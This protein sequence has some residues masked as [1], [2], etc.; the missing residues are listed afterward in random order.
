MTFGSPIE[1]H[2]I[3]WPELWEEFLREAGT[4]PEEKPLAADPMPPGARGADQV[5][6]LP[7]FRGDPIAYRLTMRRADWI[8]GITAGRRV[9]EPRGHRGGTGA[10]PGHEVV[11][12]RYP[13]PGKAHVDY[14]GDQGRL[15]PFHQ[16]R[17][18]R[19]GAGTRGA[20]FRKRPPEQPRGIGLLS[21][22]RALPAPGG[23]CCSTAVWFMTR[24]VH[25]FLYPDGFRYQVRKDPEPVGSMGHLSRDV[26][27]I[28]LLLMGITVAAHPPP[29]TVLVVPA[30]GLRR[31]P[32]RHGGLSP[33]RDREHPGIP[34][35]LRPA[36]SAC[37]RG[38]GVRGR[39]GFPIRACRS[40]PGQ[41]AGPGRWRPATPGR[42][43][44]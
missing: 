37:L 23:S 12:S 1:E 40:W 33:D 2:L 26:A 11:F 3:L 4:T 17:W 28:S 30:G 21:A 7:R 36:G 29:D 9:F 20:Q 6:E 16:R 5:V 10:H 41:S 38:R 44:D 14:W 25:G 35:P 32:G 31:V 39:G 34:E 19:R 18:S 22:G 8:A 24:G 13:F 27:G 15:R 42:I 43:S